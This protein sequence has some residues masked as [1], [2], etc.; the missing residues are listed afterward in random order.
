[1][2]H[3]PGRKMKRD[4][5]SLRS[6]GMTI[7][8]GWSAADGEFGGDRLVAFVLDSFLG[9]RTERLFVRILG[10]SGMTA[11]DLVARLNANQPL[12]LGGIPREFHTIS[13]HGDLFLRGR[14]AVNL[15]CNR[16]AINLVCDRRAI[17]HSQ[18]P[19]IIAQERQKRMK[20]SH[21]KGTMYRAPTG[22]DGLGGELAAEAAFECGSG[23]RFKSGP[24]R[25]EVQSRRY[26]A[27]IHSGPYRADIR[28]R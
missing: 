20:A 9:E 23:I 14:T 27:D 4:P 16:R 17:D 15:P 2:G 26:Q 19:P 22:G 10:Q 12:R 13:V 24:C 7:L 28:E 1:M 18:F 8:A 5:S 21:E 25:A 11:N 6:L 3:A